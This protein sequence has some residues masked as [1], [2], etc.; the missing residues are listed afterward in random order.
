MTVW[1]DNGTT[2]SA[3]EGLDVTGGT[4]GWGCGYGAGTTS[5][6]VEMT[7]MDVAGS[8]M[9]GVGS[10]DGTVTPTSGSSNAAERLFH[11]WKADIQ[12]AERPTDFVLRRCTFWTVINTFPYVCNC[13]FY[14]LYQFGKHSMLCGIW[15]RDT[16]HLPVFIKPNP[17][18]KKSKKRRYRFRLG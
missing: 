10:G 15:N 5:Q 17:S 16:A 12:P 14:H 9:T 3:I 8:E 2:E 11:Y 1:H 18:R 13:P 7:G 4:D 6:T